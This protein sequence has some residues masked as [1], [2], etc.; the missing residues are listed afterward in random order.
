MAATLYPLHVPPT[1][2]HTVGLDYLAHLHVSNS[3]ES[4]LIV[5]DHLTRVAHFL[6]CTKSV[7]TQET[8][9]LF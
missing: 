9:N 5:I 6:P 7:T 2:W 3:F 8:A 4:V 1:P